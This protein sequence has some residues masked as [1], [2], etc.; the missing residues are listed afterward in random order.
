MNALTKISL[1]LAAI[2]SGLTAGL[3]W[4]YAYSVMPALRTVDDKTFVTVMNKINVVILN[5]WFGFCFGGGLAL[6]VIAMIMVLISRNTAAMPWAIASA[7]LFLA[8]V[9]VTSVINVPLNNGLATVAATAD[10]GA[11][12]AARAH[13]EA[14]WNKANVIRAGLHTAAF[15]AGCIALLAYRIRP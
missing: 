6:A 2:T 5:G 7:V 8:A 3:F 4:G 14:P 15:V 12:A 11:L 10:P 13:F 1:V 9:I